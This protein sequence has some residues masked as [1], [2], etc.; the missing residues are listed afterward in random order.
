M[1][2]TNQQSSHTFVTIFVHLLMTAV[3]LCA[4]I[5]GGAGGAAGG[6]TEGERE[7][8]A[9]VRLCVSDIVTGGIAEEPDCE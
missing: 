2:I 5:C 8:E 9:I 1:N 4:N 7:R 6:E 3:R